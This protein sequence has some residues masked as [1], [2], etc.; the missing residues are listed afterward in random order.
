MSSLVYS[1]GGVILLEILSFILLYRFTNWPGKQVAFLVGLIAVGG[2]LPF[3]VMTWKGLDQFAIHIAFYIM[4]PY[5]LGIITSNWE[6]REGKSNQAGKSWFHWGPATMVAFFIVLAVVDSIIITLAE[7]GM[8]SNSLAR[9][10][11][12]PQSAKTAESKFPGTIYH[13]YKEKE[14]L[15]NAYQEERRQ[16]EKR[17][18]Q[19]KK[20]FESAP[21]RDKPAVFK[22]EVRDRD[23]IAI[24]QAE[25]TGQ[26][27]RPSDKQLDIDF[28]LTEIG[29]GLY[30][31]EL[32]FPAAGRW[33]LVLH[34][35]R[36]DQ[37]HEIRAKTRVQATPR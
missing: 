37:K 32:S 13:D 10:L 22:V 12:E 4:I 9:F 36:D 25:I 17:G 5:V 34:I 35:R 28:T 6:F 2:Y 21:V 33:D 1:L 29:N 7:R 19:V 31:T 14:S 11:P 8:S 23:G 18:W 24:D 27:L 30:S 26:F 3:G 16:Q 15:F 20:G